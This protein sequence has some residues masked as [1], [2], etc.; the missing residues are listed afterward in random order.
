MKKGT[1][2]TKKIPWHF[3]LTYLFLSI[4]I[5]VAG[6][7]Y[8]VFQEKD[9]KV[10]KQNELSAIADLKVSQIAG[11]RKERIGNAEV[12][13]HNPLIR[14]YIQQWL[15]K[16]T[17]ELKQKIKTYM[18][19]LQ[20]Y[21]QY[22]SVILLNTKGN[23]QLA[24]PDEKEVIEPEA[25]R[26]VAEAINTKKTV[27]SDFYQ[28]TTTNTI[29]LSLIVPLVV[30][31]SHD[32]FPIGALLLH[33]DPYIFLY[34]LIQ[35]WPTPSP[36]AETLLVR[37]EGNEVVFLN[38]LRHRKGTALTLKFSI[39]DKQLPAVLAVK[40]VQG[41]VEGTD[42]RG[43][44]VL[45]ATRAIPDSRWF[46]VSKIDEEEIH[47][48][49]HRHFLVV[50]IVVGLL[51]IGSGLII[52][53]FWRKRAEEALQER[54]M[55]IDR[56]KLEWESTVDSIPQIICLIDKQGYILRTNRTVEQ[57]NLGKVVSVK[58][59]TLHELLHPSCTDSTCYLETFWSHAREEL[60]HGRSTEC[61]VNDRL[62]GR[63]LHVQVQP[64]SPKMYREGKE[65][66]SYAVIIIYDIT[67][68][69][70]QEDA[71]EQIRHQNELIL[72]SAGEGILGVDLQGNHTFVNP[73]AARML[74]YED[75]ELIGRHSHTIWHHLKADGS[76]YPEKECPIY[77]AYKDGAVHHVRDE[78]FGKKMAQVFQWHTRALLF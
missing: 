7:F 45:A 55:L 4:G 30:Q 34:P 42:Y 54:L 61:E 36:T 72:N 5:C 6:Y 21:H 49:I 29:C 78:V 31:Q 60:K 73:S 39:N 13:F 20:K 66:D 76:P 12:I 40:G 35:L 74:G 48:P 56:A 18:E 11:W 71:V 38:E 64:I 63:H 1:L 44:P 14:P 27:F 2:I 75:E 16:K 22:K 37:R 51:I 46:I 8:F 70:Q 26:L 53:L 33:I 47:A 24:V 50:S 59:K 23:V 32:T 68:R 19:S 58:A 10:E 52:Y 15:E 25:Q 69:R 67:K 3:I 28:N 41:V 77:A 57:W 9:Y 62:I 43:V 65:I 17:P